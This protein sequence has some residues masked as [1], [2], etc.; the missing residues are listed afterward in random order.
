MYLRYSD[1]DDNRFRQPGMFSNIDLD[2]QGPSVNRQSFP[3]SN[4]IPNHSGSFLM[5]DEGDI[6]RL[7]DIN[8]P[9]Q[10]AVV[11]FLQD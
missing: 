8:H 7:V 11:A 5:N 9:H 6:Q 2:P 1:I 10:S 3:S 4:P